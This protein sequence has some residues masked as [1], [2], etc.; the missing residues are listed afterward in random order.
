MKYKWALVNSS[1]T[2]YWFWGVKH[3]VTR[4]LWLIPPLN[5]SNSMR[6]HFPLKILW[7]LRPKL[8]PLKLPMMV[9]GKSL[10]KQEMSMD[11]Y[12]LWE[13]RILTM[14]HLLYLQIIFGH[15]LPKAL[16][17]TWMS[18]MRSWGPCLLILMA[19]NYLRFKEI[20]S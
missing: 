16:L 6:I 7:V 10:L 8:E 18:I 19:R 13:L 5:L 3:L 11:W 17:N 15:S 1:Y 14:S 4:K 12:Q 2:P 20:Y 9:M